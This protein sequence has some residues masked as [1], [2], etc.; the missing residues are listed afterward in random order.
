ME[1]PRCRLCKCADRDKNNLL[2]K[3]KRARW[4][5]QGNL[6][7][8]TK[9][10]NL[11]KEAHWPLQSHP[12]NLL[13]RQTDPYYFSLIHPTSDEGICSPK[14]FQSGES[15]L[16]TSEKFHLCPTF[17]KS[18]WLHFSC[19]SAL[20]WYCLPLMESWFETG[21]PPCRSFKGELETWSTMGGLPAWSKAPIVRY[22]SLTT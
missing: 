22:L 19:C 17:K 3:T 18:G 11:L 14:S 1:Y 4:L 7:F 13:K 21:A 12:S 16:I 2:G 15:F 20:A 9:Q 5:W 10:L 6:G 8:A